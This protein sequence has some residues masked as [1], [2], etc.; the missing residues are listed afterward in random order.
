M[1]TKLRVLPEPVIEDKI[2][3]IGKKIAIKYRKEQRTKNGKMLFYTSDE[4][5]FD[6]IRKEEGKYERDKYIKETYCGARF[7][8]CFSNEN[9]EEKLTVAFIN[10]DTLNEN[11]RKYIEKT[12]KKKKKKK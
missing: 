4:D 5:L 8:I 3:R 2:K 12:K 6:V 1:N 9:G 7:L 11:L 10:S